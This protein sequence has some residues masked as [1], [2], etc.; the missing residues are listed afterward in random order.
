[1]GRDKALLPLS[2]GRL[3][4]QRQLSV[5]GEIAPT[6]VFV[7]GSAREGFPTA[8]RVLADATPGLGP[9][10]GI[11]V[12][13]EAMQSPR[14]VVLAIDLP[15][16]T[17]SFLRQLLAEAPASGVIPQAVD[18]FFEPLAAVYPRTAGRLANEMLN[19]HDRSLQTFARSLL[20]SGQAIAHPLTASE[21]ALFTNWNAPG[22]VS[23]RERPAQ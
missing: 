12:A 18:G 20:E 21:T 2:D 8:A 5:L 15:S 14:L 13:L 7:S 11:A 19:G 6:E 22:D 10:S 4:W 23:V 16:M 9:L 1:M 3:L 17:A